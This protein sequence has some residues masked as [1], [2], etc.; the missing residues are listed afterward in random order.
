MAAFAKGDAVAISELYTEDCKV[1][2][3][4]S[5]TLTG[6]N[7]N[8]FLQMQHTSYCTDRCGTGFH[9]SDKCWRKEA[10]SGNR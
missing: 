2:P 6:R 9:R 5:D 7:G 1:M 3:T 10:T 4:G 8:S